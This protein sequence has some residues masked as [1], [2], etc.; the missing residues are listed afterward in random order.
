MKYI[1]SEKDEETNQEPP[2]PTGFMIKGIESR[3]TLSQAGIVI[4]I[5]AITSLLVY[6]FFLD[7]KSGKLSK[8]MFTIPIHRMHKKFGRKP[9]VPPNVVNIKNL[10]HKAHAKIDDKEVD[11]AR[12][13]Y[14]EIGTLYKYLPNS[15]KDELYPNSIN[16]FH[17]INDPHNNSYIPMSIKPLHLIDGTV[18]KNLY[19]LIDVLSKLD[20]DTFFEHVNVHRNDLSDWI[21]SSI[22]KKELGKHIS[23]MTNKHEM[24][25]VLINHI[26]SDNIN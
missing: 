14:D 10:I 22:G 3:P 23:R 2:L 8:N 6:Y 16:L 11:E 13:I 7:S 9:S 5:I 26:I 21:E 20:E 1:G 24:R 4:G 19:Q 15:T 17:R 25:E 18:V 12:R